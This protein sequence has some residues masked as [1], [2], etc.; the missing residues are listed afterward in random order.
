[1]T[2]AFEFARR[3]G[4]ISHATETDTGDL[5]TCFTEVDVF[6][7]F[8]WVRWFG[9]LRSLHKG[10]RFHRRSSVLTD[11]C[12]VREGTHC[13]SGYDFYE[14]PTCCVAHQIC[15]NRFISSRILLNA[16]A[17]H[18]SVTYA[19]RPRKNR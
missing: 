11:R 14:S 19:C 12:D 17:C 2:T 6:H 18:R 7:S 5:E 10:F 1:M 9:S 15:S 3:G 8:Y 16:C 13:A 4:T